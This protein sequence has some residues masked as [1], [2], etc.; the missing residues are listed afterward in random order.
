MG[1]GSVVF[2]GCACS[3]ISNVFTLMLMPYSISRKNTH[4][5]FYMHMHTLLNLVACYE[6]APDYNHKQNILI[7]R[8]ICDFDFWA[9]ISIMPVP[10]L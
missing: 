3:M 8:F 1:R 10:V 7:L 5:H 6:P 4:T 9:T 2:A